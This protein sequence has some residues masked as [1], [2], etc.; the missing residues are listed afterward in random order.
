V[1]GVN[2]EGRCPMPDILLDPHFDDRQLLAKAIEYYCR[3]L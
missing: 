2:H 3:A 1:E